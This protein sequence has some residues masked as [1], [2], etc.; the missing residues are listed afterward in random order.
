MKWRTSFTEHPNSSKCE[1]AARIAETT[2]TSTPSS[3]VSRIKPTLSP[4][5]GLLS[6]ELAESK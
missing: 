6:R 2:P 3:I 5:K 1:A 4:F